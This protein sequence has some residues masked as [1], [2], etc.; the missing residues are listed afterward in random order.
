[1]LSFLSDIKS[2]FKTSSSQ[3][4]TY[5]KLVEVCPLELTSFSYFEFVAQGTGRKRK[6]LRILAYSILGQHYNHISLQFF[7]AVKFPGSPEASVLQQ[8]PLMPP[9]S[10]DL[11][12]VEGEDL[13]RQS[14]LKECPPHATATDLA[15]QHPLQGEQHHIAFD[16]YYPRSSPYI[17]LS[18]IPYP[19]P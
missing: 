2:N 3:K 8:Q 5:T 14:Y 12:A 17:S 18:N 4:S 15:G 16:I 7:P 6:E 9:L 10:D 13:R 1:M 19:I 11:S